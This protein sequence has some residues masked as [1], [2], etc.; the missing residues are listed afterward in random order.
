MRWT[1]SKNGSGKDSEKNLRVNGREVE[2][3]EDL[4]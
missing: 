1:F 4:D 3:G 2:E